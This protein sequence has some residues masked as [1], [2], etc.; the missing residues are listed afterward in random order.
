MRPICDAELRD[1]LVVGARSVM[2]ENVRLAAVEARRVDDRYNTLSKAV[3]SPCTVCPENPTPLWS[4]RARRVIHD[5]EEHIIHYENATFEVFGVPVG[6]LPYFRHPDPT[7]DRA[8]GFLIPRFL[9]SSIFGYALK[10]PYYQVIDPQSDLTLTPFVMT[11]DGLILELEY[12]RLFETGGLTF[13]GSGTWND[14]GGEGPVHGFVDTDGLFDIGWGIDAGWDIKFA[15]DDA[16]LRRYDYDYVDRL[17][18]EVFVKRYR[19]RRL[20]RRLGRLFP[21]PARQRAGRP[22]PAGRATAGGAQGL[23]RPAPRR[24]ARR[25]R[26]RATC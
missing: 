4:I 2:G 13:A 5:E 9:S 21:E 16:Y 6:W 7:V 24:R 25:L 23:R 19:Q 14:Y 18:S 3:Y 17:T 12:R 10:V 15:S 1:G 11:N 22:D 8:S 20:L 26:R